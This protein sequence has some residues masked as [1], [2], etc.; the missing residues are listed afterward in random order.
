MVTLHRAP[1]P[2][3]GSVVVTADGE[4]DFRARQQFDDHLTAAR[5]GC[6]HLVVDLSGVSFLDSSAL[7]VLVSHWKKLTA[8]GDALL[9]VGL[10]GRTSK[11]FWIAGL[12][13]R[14]PS[15]ATLAEA[16]AALPPAV[17]ATP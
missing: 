8:G 14:I 5:A 1:G 17:R 12:A 11:I 16:A 15:Y 7:A 13:E 2:G 6:H 9:L 10:S 3:P 4:L